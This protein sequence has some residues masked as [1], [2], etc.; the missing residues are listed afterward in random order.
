MGDE[1]VVAGC[2]VACSW[3]EDYGWES[4]F[5]EDRCDHRVLQ[6]NIFQ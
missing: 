5:M 3:D 6:M 2:G 4:H 1:I